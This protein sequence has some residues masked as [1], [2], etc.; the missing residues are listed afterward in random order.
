[1]R[2]AVWTL[3]GLLTWGCSTDPCSDQPSICLSVRV[4]GSIAGLDQLSFG[5]DAP[6][7]ETLRSPDTPGPVALPAKIALVLPPS[8]RGLVN[9][10]VVGLMREVG[11]AQGLGSVMVDGRSPIA[12]TIELTPGLKLQVNGTIGVFA[13]GATSVGSRVLM[14]GN[15]SLSNM[16]CGGNGYCVS[17]GIQP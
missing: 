5:V 8:T 2:A 11:I 7:R 12:L 9:V 1:M 6:M 14:N 4:V 13:P 16:T 17:G 15:L 10:K 3:L